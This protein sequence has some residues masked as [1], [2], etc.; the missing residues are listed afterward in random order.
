[1]SGG[2]DTGPGSSCLPRSPPP[3]TKAP[4]P[5]RSA[6]W[7]RV[8]AT[9]APPL[10]EPP[11]RASCHGE[12]RPSV[13][14]GS[15][16]QAPRPW[17]PPHRRLW[18]ARLASPGVPGARGPGR[19]SAGDGEVS[20]PHPGLASSAP[21]PPRRDP[22]DPRGRGEGA[23]VLHYCT[24]V[25]VPRGLLSPTFRF[26]F[27]YT[28]FPTFRLV[29]RYPKPRFWPPVLAGVFLCVLRLQADLCPDVRSHLL[30]GRPVQARGGPAVSLPK[31]HPSAPL[32]D[33][34]GWA[35]CGFVC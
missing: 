12:F 7:P 21:V 25:L 20:G 27:L 28:H 16:P 2:P 34:S 18:L 22:P 6:H 32:P 30:A 35:S 3:L 13:P 23:L 8:P 19:G 1:M 4:S 11:R 26:I 31:G 33:A 10:A 9:R 29:A 17:K 24:S 15:Q 5:R 14:G